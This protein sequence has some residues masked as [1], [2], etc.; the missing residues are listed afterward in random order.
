VPAGAKAAEDEGYVLSFVYDGTTNGSKLVILD[1]R[2][3]AKPPIAE[4]PLPQ[5]VPFGF[6]GNWL[7]DAS[8]G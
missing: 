8:G 2:E 3:F 1:A 5:R 4:V 6:H 7:A